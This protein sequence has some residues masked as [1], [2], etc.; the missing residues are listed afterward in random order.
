MKKCICYFKCGVLEATFKSLN[1]VALKLAFLNLSVN[2]LEV[3]KQ[4]NEHRVKYHLREQNLL[5]NS[6]VNHRSTQ[7]SSNKSS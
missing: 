7:P 6:S 4:K 3:A 5:T 1:P 2:M